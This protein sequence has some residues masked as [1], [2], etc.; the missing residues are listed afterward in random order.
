MSARATAAPIDDAR[1]HFKAHIALAVAE[2]AWANYWDLL[3]EAE[4]I[5]ERLRARQRVR[6]HAALRT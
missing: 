5:T 3:L 2:A 1:E 6:T 4:G